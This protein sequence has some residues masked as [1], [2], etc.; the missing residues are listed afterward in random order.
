MQLKR[1]AYDLPLDLSPFC[2]CPA[3]YALVAA[4]SH[5]GTIDG[6][7]YAASVITGGTWTL[8]SGTD[9]V[10]NAPSPHP[11]EVDL[12]LYRCIDVRNE[13]VDRGTPAAVA[14]ELAELEAW[15][16]VAALSFSL[17]MLCYSPEMPFKLGVFT[18]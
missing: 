3:H 17:E 6:G 13:F 16:C 15:R 10:A 11:V 8:F 14:A 18:L 9:T 5:L 1:F 4:V 12:L 2:D 7:H